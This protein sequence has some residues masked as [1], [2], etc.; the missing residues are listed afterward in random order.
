MSLYGAWTSI[1]K[2][3]AVW[4]RGSH[5]W[6]EAQQSVTC[7][8]ERLHRPHA[9]RGWTAAHHRLSCG[10]ILKLQRKGKPSLKSVC[11]SEICRLTTALRL[12]VH[13][14]LERVGGWWSLS[15]PHIFFFRSEASSLNFSNTLLMSLLLTLSVLITSDQIRLPLK[16]M[17]ILK[18]KMFFQA[19]IL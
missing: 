11:L 5:H 9:V 12:Q 15:R 17:F 4:E 3:W 14:T 19:A 13:G 6:D 10:G 1:S 18:S 2:V 16:Y 7:R 8:A